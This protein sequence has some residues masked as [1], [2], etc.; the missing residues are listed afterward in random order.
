[1]SGNFNFRDNE[2]LYLMVRLAVGLVFIYASLD[3]IA[4]PAEF[5]RI[6]NNYHLMPGILINLLA[7]V[8]PWLEAVCGVALILGI[9][10]RGSI[11]IMNLMVLMFIVAIGIN[12]IRGVNLE[13]GCFTVSSKAKGSALNLLFRDLGLLALTIYLIFNRATRFDLIKTKA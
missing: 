5:A 6:V 4:H 11:Y 12:V 13:C 1:M 8:L 10:K 9:H 2:Y 3:K 7:M